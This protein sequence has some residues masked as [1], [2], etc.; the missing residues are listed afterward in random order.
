MDANCLKINISKIEYIKFGNAR[1]LGKCISNSINFE[2]I[3][4]KQADP[5]KNLGVEMDRHLNYQKHNVN[6]CNK[7]H[8][9]LNKMRN[10]RPHLSVKNAT[11]LV[12]SL[13]ISHIDFSNGLLTGLTNKSYTILQYMQNMSAKVILNKSHR[14]VVQSVHYNSI[15]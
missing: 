6:M 15:G 3:Y 14:A 5:V 1:Q 10:L 12:L 9:N 11:Q 4:I 13:V 8:W 7:A 2:D